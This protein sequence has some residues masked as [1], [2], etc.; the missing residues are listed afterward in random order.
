MAVYTA[1]AVHFLTRHFLSH[2]KVIA[3]KVI[4]RRPFLQQA[5]APQLSDSLSETRT[6][7]QISI[8]S[9]GLLTAVGTASS[10]PNCSES[11]EEKYLFLVGDSTW[12]PFALDIRWDR[13]QSWPAL[14]RKQPGQHP[15]GMEARNPNLGWWTNQSSASPEHGNIPF[16]LLLLLCVQGQTRTHKNTCLLLIVMSKRG[17][18]PAYSLPHPYFSPRRTT[19]F[20]LPFQDTVY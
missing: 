3:L 8:V 7:P 4:Q 2:D 10:M 1:H 15:W 16:L 13:I 20:I 11:L 17:Q 19:F 12:N 5:K 9:T 14:E 6:Y 18:G